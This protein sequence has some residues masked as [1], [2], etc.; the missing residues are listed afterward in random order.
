MSP[1]GN[2]QSFS[3]TNFP[4][5]TGFISPKATTLT[6]ATETPQVETVTYSSLPHCHNAI[7]LAL[8]PWRV[9]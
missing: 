2:G 7:L 5:L 9:W 6:L 3:V 8:I 1:F 4:L